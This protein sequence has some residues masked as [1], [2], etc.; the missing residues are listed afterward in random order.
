MIQPRTVVCVDTTWTD[1]FI[2][3]ALNYVAHALTVRSA[4]GEK[5]DKSVLWTIAALLVPFSGVRRGSSA[6][7]AGKYRREPDLQNAARAGALCCVAR[8]DTWGPVQEHDLYVSK[9]EQ[10]SRK[11]A[12]SLTRLAKKRVLT[13]HNHVHG[14]VSGLTELT[15]YEFRIV[16]GEIAVESRYG[17]PLE[18]SNSWGALKWIASI[19]QLIYA[20]YT[21]YS[22]RQGQ[23]TQYGYAAFGLTVVPYMIMSLVNLVANLLSPEYPYIYIVNSE[24]M[25]EAEGLGA[26]FDGTVGKISIEES[27]FQSVRFKSVQPEDVTES[28][29][30]WIVSLG[31]D[32]VGQPQSMEIPD[33]GRHKRQDQPWHYPTLSWWI[34]LV[35]LAS[36]YAIIGG[37]SKFQ[38]GQSTS[39]ERG[40]LLTWLIWGQCSG[41]MLEVG[42]ERICLWMEANGKEKYEIF[43]AVWIIAIYGAPAIGGFVI[44]V[45]MMREFGV[46]TYL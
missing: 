15:N 16:P 22:A 32:P 37:L 42:L 11:Y 46:C 40:F 18:L 39:L 44:V 26:Q 23:I 13:N 27:K 41:V 7:A 28:G 30:G 9:P 2:F 12:L 14:E 4:P 8:S 24:L 35:A 45:K 20:S 33:I 25:D 17:G 31:E 36:P 43:W 34:T 6:I 5:W 21:L 3:F 10:E 29:K 1:I 38:A 19:V